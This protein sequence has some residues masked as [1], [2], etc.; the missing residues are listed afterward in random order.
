[1]CQLSYSICDMRVLNII[2]SFGHSQAM[3]CGE[4]ING[5]KAFRRNKLVASHFEQLPVGV[6]KVNRI[7][8]TPVDI[9]RIPDTALIQPRSN[10]CIGGMRDG[11]GEVMQVAGI[12]RIGGRIICPRGAHKEGD[13]SSITWIKVEMR[14]IWNI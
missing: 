4:Y 11:E 8:E 6:S 10:L 14:L 3:R 13:Q 2:R 1:M 9:A 12:L 5:G 7:H